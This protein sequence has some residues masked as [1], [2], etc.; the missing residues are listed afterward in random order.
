MIRLINIAIV[1]L[2]I[3]IFFSCSSYHIQKS[4]NGKIIEN[5]PFYSQLEYQC[6]PASLAGVMNYHGLNIIPEKI[7]EEIFSKSAKG[8]LTLDMLLYARSKGLKT[9][10]YSGNMDDLRF[11]I[12]SDYPLIVLVDYGFLFYKHHHFMVVIG[13]NDMGVII[14]SDTSEKQFIKTE[15]FLKIWQKT[16]YWTLLIKRQD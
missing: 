14:N 8:T 6:G 2:I 15:D 12:D 3:L 9:I 5:V 16:N 1:L 11:N 10:Q 7:A 4:Y 13:Y